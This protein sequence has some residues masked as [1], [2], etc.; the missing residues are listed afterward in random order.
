MIQID[1]ELGG[2]KFQQIKAGKENPAFAV[3]YIEAESPSA[4]RKQN[5]T[6]FDY[7]E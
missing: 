6:N 7:K 4:I 3:S 2:K 1:T 5:F